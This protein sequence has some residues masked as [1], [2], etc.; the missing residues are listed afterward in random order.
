MLMQWHNINGTTLAP[1]IGRLYSRTEGFIRDT[2]ATQLGYCGDV[3]NTMP[4]ALTP[5]RSAVAYCLVT[6][7][8]KHLC[9]Q[10]DGVLVRVVRVLLAGHLVRGVGVRGVG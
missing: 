5:C 9:A 3:W 2:L 8:K 7:A 1:L 6:D 4:H 10:V